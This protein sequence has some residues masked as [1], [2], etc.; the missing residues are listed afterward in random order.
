MTDLKKY[1]SPTWLKPLE[2]G[3]KVKTLSHDDAFAGQTMEIIGLE[4]DQKEV[5]IG[6]M[7]GWYGT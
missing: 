1:V 3:M 6:V 2:L 5:M 7:I 4:H